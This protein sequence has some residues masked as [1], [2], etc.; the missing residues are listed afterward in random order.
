MRH[1]VTGGAGFIGSHL[2]DRLMADPQNHVIC[3]DNFQTGSRANVAQ[4]LHNPRFE[5]IRHDVVE[6]FRIEVD[7]IWH[8]ACPASPRQYQRNPIATAKTCVIGTLNMLG[9]AKRCGA[10]LLL[11]S[12][13]E[14][15]GDPLVSPQVESNCGNVNCT[16]PR[17]CYDEG[18]RMAETLCFDYARMHGVSVAVARIFNTY[19]PRMSSSDGR[20]VT[21]FISQALRGEPLSIY[22]NGEQT[23]SFCYCDDLVEGL[24]ALM[25]HAEMEGPVNLGNPNEITISELASRVIALVRPGLAVVHQPLPIDDPQRRCPSIER[26]EMFLGWRP[27]VD[28]DQGLQATITDLAGQLNQAGLIAL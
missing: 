4:W 22:G 11:A 6:P 8:L 28:L 1:L 12:T 20:V 7:R 13:S 23:R 5:L 15:Y 16:G 25:N 21:N 17:A 9:L 2:I 3:L 10:R 19:G 26:A 14:V 24:L 18:K 27:N